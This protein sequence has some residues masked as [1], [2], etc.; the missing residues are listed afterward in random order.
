MSFKLLFQTERGFEFA[1]KSIFN[2]CIYVESSANPGISNLNEASFKEI[3]L[4]R[5]DQSKLDVPNIAQDSS[6]KS[7]QDAEA[8][9]IGRKSF[10]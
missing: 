8:H 4:T 5:D 7:D 10:E 2:Q 1:I 3:Q 6:Q 9:R